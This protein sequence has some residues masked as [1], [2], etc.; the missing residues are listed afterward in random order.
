MDPK[1]SRMIYK[2]LLKWPILPHF[3]GVLHLSKK[4]SK[5]RDLHTPL[6]FGS[7]PL[8]TLEDE[9]KEETEEQASE[10]EEDEEEGSEEEGNRAREESTT[11]SF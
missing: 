8:W 1:P 10:E 7:G 5:F 9:D 4:I 6:D 3:H 11:D 2:T